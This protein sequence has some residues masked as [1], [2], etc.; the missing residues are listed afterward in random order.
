MD[1]ESSHK[2]N[3]S[4]KVDRRQ[5]FLGACF[6]I[7]R[8]KLPLRAVTSGVLGNTVELTAILREPVS[9][10]LREVRLCSELLSGEIK[11]MPSAAGNAIQSPAGDHRGIESC[12]G[13]GLAFATISGAAA[14][15]ARAAT[16]R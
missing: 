3:R 6:H 13:R 4:G 8:V 1:T 12:Q 9:Q 5:K 10:S 14:G 16:Q 15:V 11:S 2:I 7:Y